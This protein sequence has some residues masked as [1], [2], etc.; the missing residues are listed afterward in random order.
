MIIKNLIEENILSEEQGEKLIRKK[1]QEK[2]FTIDT[3]GTLRTL[4][5]SGTNEELIKKFEI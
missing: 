1:L 5:L 2:M 4:F 3:V